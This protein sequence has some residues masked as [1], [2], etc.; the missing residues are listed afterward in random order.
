MP[1]VPIGQLVT[2]S[3]LTGL[4]LRRSRSLDMYVMRYRLP[5]LRLSN[6]SKLMEMASTGLKPELLPPSK[7]KEAVDHAGPSPQLVP[8]KVLTISQLESSYPS[9]SNSLLIV[10]V[11]CMVTP[12]A[13]VVFSKVLSNTTRIT[14][15]SSSLNIHIDPE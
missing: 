10:P 9:L 13:T 7:I 11:D 12:V 1:L 15:Q 14:W 4:L 2:T 6:L 5:R 3:S 8:W